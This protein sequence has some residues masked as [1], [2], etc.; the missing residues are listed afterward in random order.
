MTSGQT[1]QLLELI[2]QYANARLSASRTDLEQ[3]TK[4][5]RTPS[6]SPHK[7]LSHPLP[8]LST[9]RSLGDN[10]M[11]IDTLGD[12]PTT[13][14]KGQ[15]DRQFPSNGDTT[16]GPSRHVDAIPE[17]H[18][19]VP[20]DGQSGGNKLYSVKLTSNMLPQIGQLA[21][22]VL[23]G[24]DEKVGIANGCLHSASLPTKCKII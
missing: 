21:R 12:L 8:D 10:D 16:A 9:L 5:P 4:P 19:D 22:D 2:R 14:G 11:D 24:A 20:L 15:S 1:S 17:A 13:P 18:L 23:R 6:K 3:P 7:D